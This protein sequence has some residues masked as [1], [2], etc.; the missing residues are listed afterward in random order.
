MQG[1]IQGLLSDLFSKNLSTECAFKSA[2]ILII[3]GIATLLLRRAPA[4]WRHMVWFAAML[5]LWVLP[6]LTVLLPSWNFPLIHVS[7]SQAPTAI[8]V[9]EP[10][11][12][13]YERT[14]ELP[15]NPVQNLERSADPTTFTTQSKSNAD[16]VPFPVKASP[17]TKEVSRTTILLALWAIGVL[18]SLFPLMHRSMVLRRIA[19]GGNLVSDERWGTCLTRASQTLGLRKSFC[20][21]QSEWCGVPLTF[22]VLHPVLVLPLESNHWTE[23]RKEMV[24]LHE[25][26]HIQRGDWF[27]QMTSRLVAC[28]YWFNPLVWFALG[29]MR[30][31]R[32]LACDD[33]VLNAGTKPSEY[34]RELLD[35]AQSIRW[36]RPQAAAAITMA[37]LGHLEGRVRAILDSGRK[38]GRLTR[39]VALMIAVVICVTVCWIGALTPTI[40]ASEKTPPVLVKPRDYQPIISQPRKIS[41]S[42]K[43]IYRTARGVTGH[44]IDAEVGTP[45]EEFWTSVGEVDQPTGI[46]DWKP[47]VLQHNGTFHVS[48]V[49]RN[50]GSPLRQLRRNQHGI[51]LIDRNFPTGQFKIRAASRGH[52]WSESEVFSGEGLDA[53]VEFT[54][55]RRVPRK[56]TL[57]GV[58]GTPAAEVTVHF[59]WMEGQGRGGPQEA[60]VDTNGQGQFE[61]P[62]AF[63][64]MIVQVSSEEGYCGSYEDP[65][66]PAVTLQMQQ[67]SR[68]EGIIKK[69]N[70]PVPQAKLEL[71]MEGASRL[72]LSKSDF[73]EKW[74]TRTDDT[75]FY[76]FGKI[77]PGIGT[78]TWVTQPGIGQERWQRISRSTTVK[79]H[80]G[81]MTQVHIGGKGWSVI[82]RIGAIKG[83]PGPLEFPASSR[84]SLTPHTSLFTGQRPNS[85]WGST[86]ASAQEMQFW[87]R[88]AANP[89][90]FGAQTVVEADG[91]FRFDD[92]PPVTC[93]LHITFAQNPCPEHPD[94]MTA[95]GTVL[96]IVP[97]VIPEADRDLGI[98]ELQPI[99]EERLEAGSEWPGIDQESTQGSFNPSPEDG[100]FVLIHF[101]APW[102]KG[103]VEELA[104][105]KRIHKQFGGDTRFRMAGICL[106]SSLEDLKQLCDQYG[107]T[108]EQIPLRD[109]WDNNLM[110]EHGIQRLPSAFLI[111]PDWKVLAAD[112][113]GE[114]VCE[115]VKEALTP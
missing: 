40:A 45:I 102:H 42:L 105:M 62:E 112:A 111:S 14:K 79:V 28:L 71:L 60:R 38:R 10:F 64:P 15:P 18:I 78:L 109:W 91:I 80:A 47:P 72:D 44:V 82:G 6:A 24:L 95:A 16:Q 43:A 27:A 55:K 114:A 93:E 58:D 101:W 29:R 89:N 92:I 22:G 49:P 70:L 32:E 26:G 88:K 57:L 106:G 8:P 75:G 73:R 77:P 4:A 99:D 97:Q 31:E 90:N 96:Q 53:T 1:F 61:Y 12:P 35:I 21:L 39:R 66:S 85:P 37:R 81:P 98:I 84:I 108:W 23:T 36:S 100:K 63:G 68:V 19:L 25:L 69:G 17:L 115:A 54:L 59:S 13:S 20:C 5:S 50:P 87:T 52:A 74:T 9:A 103:S 83:F 3:A 56:G 48:L 110:I 11:K 34:A 7:Q 41:P 46:V 67:W 113:R 65:A 51:P 2:V 76:R 107:I 94:L 33:L 30:V 104:V 86:Y